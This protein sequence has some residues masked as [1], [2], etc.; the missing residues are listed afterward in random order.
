MS[1]SLRSRKANK[2][3]IEYFFEGSSVIDEATGTFDDGEES[4]ADS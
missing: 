4:K 2:N 3:N 1:N